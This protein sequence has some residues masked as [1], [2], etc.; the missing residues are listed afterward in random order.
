MLKTTRLP[1]MPASR[2]NNGDGQVIEFGVS[3]SS[4]GKASQY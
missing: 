2:R 3:N 1:D 4:D